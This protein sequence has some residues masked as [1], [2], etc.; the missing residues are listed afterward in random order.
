MKAGDV[1]GG[2]YRL[3]ASAGSGGAGLVWRGTDLDSG[4]LVA[5]KTARTTE[6]TLDR[7]F[8]REAETLAKL[9][10]PAIVSHLGH[11]IV[12]E[13]LYLV[14]EWLEGEDLGSRL[15]KSALSVE[16][17]LAIA[18]QL[19]AALGAAH[20]AGVVHRDVK[21]QNVFL[22]GKRPDRVKLLDFGIARQAGPATYTETGVIVG[23]PTYMAPEQARGRSELD[24]RVD[25]YGLG[26]LLFHCLAGRPPFEGDTVEGVIA[27]VLT[28]PAP[29]LLT[30]VPHVA[31]TLDSLVA[32]MLAKDPAQRP[33]DGAAVAGALLGN[34]P[35]AAMPAPRPKLPSIAVLPFQDLSAA[36]D[37]EYL[38]EG[39]AEEIIH[40]LAH[41]EG[42]RVAARRSTFRFR[43]SSADAREIGARLDVDTVLEG[44]VRRAGDRL[45]VTVQL[46][47]TAT[48]T[49][50][51]SRRFDGQLDDVFAMQDE[52]AGGVG[53]ALR[54][55][56][57][58]PEKE[59]M[60]RPGT[61]PEAYEEVLRGRQLL[62][63]LS[64]SS[65]AKAVAHFERAI[66]IDP[67]YAPAWSGLAQIH[68]RYDEWAAGGDEARAAADRAS[69][70][71]LELAPR[72]S[73]SH[74]ARGHVLKMSRRYAEAEAAFREAIRLNPNSCD[75]HSLY[76]AMCVQ[77]GRLAEAA[78]LYGRAAELTPE[79]VQCCLLAAQCLR[80][81]GRASEAA[82]MN[83]ETIRRAERQLAID[84]DDTRVLSL[85]SGALIFEGQRERGLEWVG[86]A[87]ALAPDDPAVLY[88]AG[89]SYVLLGEL[90]EA[91]SC[92]EGTMGRGMGRREWIEHDPDL[93]P[94]RD[95]PRFQAML[96]RLK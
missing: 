42:L 5:V 13:E 93:D 87:R 83:R 92:L 91:L 41:I 23:T 84:P 80:A 9:R 15:A 2:R 29:R 32:S 68:S 86:R 26:A 57:S 34:D 36:R 17:S 27:Q 55:L 1:L 79:D 11:G 19:A 71:A 10:H 6:D 65:Y 45:R 67:Q 62:N 95:H 30:I 77:T 73:D 7:R 53:T 56:L 33:A 43:G 21:P 16:E 31:R 24:P 76:G 39:I 94:L 50:R 35:T 40:A 37:Q 20:A 22:V 96:A 8:L 89:C 59:A 58:P 48:G 70:K 3:D 12:G 44:G 54:G 69:R 38:C 64:E 18:G 75:A 52:I 74:V 66:A 51:W 85:A 47:D 25:V 81:V 49:Q 78:A 28:Q 14:M 82:A 88:N 46:V 61:R 90:E 72:L 4:T 60:R 63:A